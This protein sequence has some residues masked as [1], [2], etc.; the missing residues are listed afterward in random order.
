MLSCFQTHFCCKWLGCIVLPLLAN[1]H[2]FKLTR[3]YKML[4]KPLI[5]LLLSFAA[6]SWTTEVLK[7]SVLLGWCF[8]LHRYSSISADTLLPVIDVYMAGIYNVGKAARSPP[9]LVY[10][11]HT[12]EGAR[13]TV[14]W[15]GKGIVY[16]TGGL[17]IKS[18]VSDGTRVGAASIC[19]CICDN[20]LLFFLFILQVLVQ[21]SNRFWAD[22]Q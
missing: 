10:L 1:K 8:A 18:R 3:K 14:A 21:H 2:C 19:M 4:G 20:F 7:V 12:P 22:W 16:D 17:C 9:A 6:R 11:S 5:L 13:K 15:V